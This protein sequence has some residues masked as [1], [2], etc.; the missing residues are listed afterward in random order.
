MKHNGF[1][2]LALFLLTLVVAPAFAAPAPGG[3]DGILGHYEA[4]RT[5]LLADRTAGVP[6]HAKA[7]AGL[8]KS[9]PADLGPQIAAAA[10]KL[11]AAKDLNAARDAFYEL[12]KPLVRWREAAGSK[13]HVVAFCPMKKRSWLQPK[14]EIGNPYYG[15]SMPRCGEVVSK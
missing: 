4:V 9:A 10:F 3:F 13:R 6:D 8:S 12:S 1:F 14:G 11:A 2:L 7:I 15:K 5:A